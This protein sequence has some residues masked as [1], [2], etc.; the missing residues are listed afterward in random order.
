MRGDVDL[1]TGHRYG[2]LCSKC[3]TLVAASKGDAERMSKV[4]RYLRRTRKDSPS[5]ADET[6]HQLSGTEEVYPKEKIHDREEK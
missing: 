3:N 6:G 5:R 2:I 4:A 1:A